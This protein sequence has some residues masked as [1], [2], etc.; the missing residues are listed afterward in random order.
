MQSLAQNG[1]KNGPE[2][3]PKMKRISLKR[4]TT[5]DSRTEPTPRLDAG[6]AAG[7]EHPLQT[8]RVVQ[9]RRPQGPLGGFF[10]RKRCRKIEIIAVLVSCTYHHSI[11]HSAVASCQC[12]PTI[13][14][15]HSFSQ[16]FH[17]NPPPSWARTSEHIAAV[18]YY[19]TVCTQST[20]HGSPAP[21]H[22]R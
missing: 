18:N 5:E 8:P 15:C 4:K 16:R 11:M 9:R 17:V 19:E 22:M 3:V 20:A 10:P 6:D 1:N 12:S 2:K 14:C 13:I 21:A 7:G